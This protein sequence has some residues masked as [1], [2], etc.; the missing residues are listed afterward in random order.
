[1]PAEVQPLCIGTDS[2][3]IGEVS[4]TPA[5][6]RDS[7]KKR[8]VWAHEPQRAAEQSAQRDLR[9][10]QLLSR[11]EHSVTKLDAQDDGKRSR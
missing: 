7:T 3:L 9:M 11:D 1:M 2:A 8:L 10:A 5:K 6:D 4:W